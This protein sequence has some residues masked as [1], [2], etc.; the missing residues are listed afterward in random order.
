MYDEV[1]TMDEE[2]DADREKDLKKAKLTLTE[3]CVALAIALTCVS[4]HA[5]FLGRIPRFLNGEMGFR[6]Y[7]ILTDSSQS[8]KSNTLSTYATCPTALWA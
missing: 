1:L 3:C 7:K 4:L 5:V 6:K 8:S 2:K